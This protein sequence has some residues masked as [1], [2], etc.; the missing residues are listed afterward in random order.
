MSIDSARTHC[1]CVH[2]GTP[3]TAAAQDV[4]WTIDL[5]G[6][7]VATLAPGE[8][9]DRWNVVCFPHPINELPA[10]SVSRHV[11]VSRSRGQCPRARGLTTC[12]PAS[13]RFWSLPVGFRHVR[14]WPSTPRAI[15]APWR[16]RDS[17]RRSDRSQNP[18]R[19]PLHESGCRAM[20]RRPAK[21]HS[22]EPDTIL[23][24]FAAL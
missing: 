9:I 3:G 24:G 19:S 10:R 16:T 21:A 5:P 13:P 8:A 11:D 1:Q 23:P 12:S 2:A 4:P 7:G 17:F 6:F 14:A 20:Y 18:P 22:P 15:P